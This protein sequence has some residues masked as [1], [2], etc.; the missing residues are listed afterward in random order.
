MK[1]EQ[2]HKNIDNDSQFC[3][4]CGHD[5]NKTDMPKSRELNSEQKI[6]LVASFFLLI[7]IPVY[8]LSRSL[9][10]YETTTRLDPGLVVVLELL[11][12]V[13][14]FLIYR[15]LGGKT[16]NPMDGIVSL[17]KKWQ[18]LLF[19][20]GI[21]FILF[22][23][24]L[25]RSN[26]GTSYSYN[27]NLIQE[28]PISDLSFNESQYIGKSY[29]GSDGFRLV[30]KNNNFSYTANNIKVRVTFGKTKNGPT[31]D[32]RDALI[33]DTIG[34]GETK[35]EDVYVY[36]PS[37]TVNSFWWGIQITGAGIGR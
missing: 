34:P 11:V 31:V 15:K 28:F 17:F 18:T 36:T 24:I 16:V 37:D 2:C 4:H 5:Q 3:E 25:G 21:A 30:I 1:C 8:G 19:V 20:G 22:L 7:L 32:T 9:S 12:I 29:N 14:A 26:S 13:G 10:K 27:N 33:Y 23:I 6:L 35:T